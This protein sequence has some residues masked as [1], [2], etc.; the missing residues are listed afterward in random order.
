M[1]RR[2]LMD[3]QK[4]PFYRHAE[5]EFFLARRNGEIVGRIGAI[6]NHNHNKEHRENVGFFGF[7]ECINDQVVADALFREAREW[8]KIRGVTAMR[9]PASPSVNDEYGLLV[10][11]FDKPPVVLMPYNLP[12]YPT[13]VERAGLTKVKDLYAYHVSKDKVFTDRLMRVTELVRQ[14]EGLTF[15]SLNMKDFNSEVA[16]IKSIYNRA[17]QYNWGAVP[18]T[19]EEF[20]A[21]AKDLKPVVVPELVIIAE[22]KG[23]PIG[24]ALSLPDLNIALKYNAK[25]YLLPGLLRLFWHKK[26]INWARI[27]VLGVIPERQ[28]TGAAGVLFYET[29]KR[30]VEKGYTEGEA[31]WVLEDNVMMN[32][33]AELLN[34]ERTKTYRIYEMTF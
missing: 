4:N 33:S 9:G 18:M 5:A 14:R 2:K 34:A 8:L 10:E 6:I 31:S 16:L 26:K 20:D 19:D 32:R 13:L 29:A 3:K 15:R 30:C 1:D 24:F 7:F 25:G 23:E 21:M 22:Y 11:G 28:K 17:W 12:Y 27:I